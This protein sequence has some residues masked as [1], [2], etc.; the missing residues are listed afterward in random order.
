M[1]T[2]EMSQW[3]PSRP[4]PE[5]IGQPFTLTS[6]SHYLDRIARL[7]GYL[8]RANDPPPGN[9]VMW[10]GLARITDIAI[11]YSL[12]AARCG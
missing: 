6:L 8:G 10:L 9:I 12:S 5:D 11:G 4:Q 3:L 1:G 2:I 7:G